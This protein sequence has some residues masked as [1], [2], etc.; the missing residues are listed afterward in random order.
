MRA[1]LTSRILTVAL[2]ANSHRGISM[3]SFRGWTKSDLAAEVEALRL[4]LEDAH[5]IIAGALGYGSVDDDEAD[6]EDEEFVEDME[7][8]EDDD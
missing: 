6:D 5:S 4:K 8:D 3:P 2:Q 1:H 7:F